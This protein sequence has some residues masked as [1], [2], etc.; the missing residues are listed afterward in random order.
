MKI[1]QIL[2]ITIATFLSLIFNSCTKISENK[3][4]QE[5]SPEETV[6][7]YFEA[8]NNKDQDKMESVVHEDKKSLV[9]ALENSIQVKLIECK[10]ETDNNKILND[11]INSSFYSDAYEKKSLIQFLILNISQVYQVEV[12]QM[13]IIIINIT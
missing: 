6:Q 11:V 1:S 8:F 5:L 9:Y 2:L 12:F 13:E 3:V 10:E 7:Y 4:H